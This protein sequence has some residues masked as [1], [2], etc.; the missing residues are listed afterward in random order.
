MAIFEWTPQYSVGVR[1][2]DKQHQ[3]LFFLINNLHD[4]MTKG[5]GKKAVERVLE[6]LL[7]YTV[8]HFRDEE[9]LMAKH[10]YQWLEDH[11][12]QHSEFVSK[13][14]GF[15]ADFKAGNTFLSVQILGFLQDWL[16]KHIKGT[17]MQYGE[18][19]R[20]KGVS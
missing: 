16:T 2:L 19:F 1:Q 9:A 4:S 20:Q 18:L 17:D 8:T 13:V 7:D 15:Q 5:E 14:E 12:A 6:N 10:G 11:K 3:K